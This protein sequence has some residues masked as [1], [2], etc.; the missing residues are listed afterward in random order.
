MAEQVPGDVTI[1]GV[2]GEGPTGG[3]KPRMEFV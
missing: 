1:D 2:T 3:W